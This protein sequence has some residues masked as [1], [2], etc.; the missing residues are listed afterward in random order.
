MADPLAE[1][2]EDDDLPDGLI[3]LDLMDEVEAEDRSDGDSRFVRAAGIGYLTPV[4]STV[5]PDDF[6]PL[7][8]RRPGF[9]RLRHVI[10]R[11]AFM[12]EDLAPRYGYDWARLVVLLDTPDAVVRAQRPMWTTVDSESEQTRTTEFSS[13]LDGL[14][15]VR[16]AQT[17]SVSTKRPEQRPIVTAE[18]R[19]ADG[20]GWKYLAQPGAPLRPRLEHTD[21]L[22]ELPCSASELLLRLDSEAQLRV[23][24]YGVFETTRAAAQQPQ[25]RFVLPLGSPPAP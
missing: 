12:V 22:I 11:F 15:A 17:R 24:R 18:N 19:G 25:R 5:P 23:R 3:R 1:P 6:P 21:A 2:D 16:A 8:R 13:T 14:L 7:T 20:F 10:V 4:L 9:D